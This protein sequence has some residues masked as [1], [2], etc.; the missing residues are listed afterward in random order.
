MC[1]YKHILGLIPCQILPEENGQN[2]KPDLGEDD[3]FTEDTSKE[4]ELILLTDEHLGKLYVFALTWA[5]GAFLDVEDRLKF[6]TFIREKLS[7]LDL[8][9]NSKRHPDVC[10]NLSI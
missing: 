4:E 1:G 6:D 5:V 2:V 8:P 9:V 10:V 7:F 3:D